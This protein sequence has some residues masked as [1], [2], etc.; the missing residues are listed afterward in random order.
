M[1]CNVAALTRPSTIT[2]AVSL[3][4]GGVYGHE[5]VTQADTGHQGV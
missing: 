3:F 1:T 4:R 2:A 5:E